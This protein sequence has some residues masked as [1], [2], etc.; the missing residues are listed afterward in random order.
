MVAW[1]SN[2]WSLHD[3]AHMRT[4]YMY[5][6]CMCTN[7]K[8]CMPIDP[9][10]S[11][12][13]WNYATTWNLLYL[14]PMQSCKTIW[15]LTIQWWFTLANL[16]SRVDQCICFLHIH[17]HT[18]Q[19]WGSSPSRPHIQC[20]MHMRVCKVKQMIWNWIGAKRC[21]FLIPCCLKSPTQFC[22]H[23]ILNVQAGRLNAPIFNMYGCLCEW[24]LFHVAWRFFQRCR[25]EGQNAPILHVS[26]MHVKEKYATSLLEIPQ[27]I[28]LVSNFTAVI[29]HVFQG[30]CKVSCSLDSEW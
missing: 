17:T 15:H 29:Y 2:T 19:N 27:G 25:W 8:F 28:G 1:P 20:P 16:T 4:S 13:T 3:G 21:K 22:E 30:S 5:A 14:T 10:V 11:Q 26:F 24:D 6:P 18:W 7:G 23:W 12:L 9:S